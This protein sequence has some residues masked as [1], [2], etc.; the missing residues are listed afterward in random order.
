[1]NKVRITTTR[2]MLSREVEG[3]AYGEWLAHEAHD[4]SGWRISHGPSGLGTYLLVD[5][6]TSDEAR[7]IARKLS[8]RIPKLVVVGDFDAFK[9]NIHGYSGFAA[10]EFRF[11]FEAIAAEELM[12]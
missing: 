8:R 11:I 7:R 10:D 3:Y 6:L 9:R 12:H 5:D 4:S 2:G 1:M